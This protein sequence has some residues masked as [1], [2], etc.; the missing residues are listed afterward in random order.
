MSN[1]PGSQTAI[2]PRGTT[3]MEYD[4]GL[5]DGWDHAIAVLSYRSPAF[6]PPDDTALVRSKRLKVAT[7]KGIITNG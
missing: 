5:L 6:I 1:E 4:Q 7:A 2:L 3:D